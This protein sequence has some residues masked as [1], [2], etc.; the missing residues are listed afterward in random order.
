MKTPTQKRSI[1]RSIRSTWISFLTSVRSEKRPE[2]ANLAFGELCKVLSPIWKN[3]T[4]VERQPFV[5][6]YVNDRNRFLFDKLNLT[7][8]DKRAL[9]LLRLH[10]RKQRQTR[11]KSP[12]SAYMCF[13]LVERPKI[14]VDNATMTF[15]DV[16]RELGRIWRTLTVENRSVYMVQSQL[17]KDRYQTAMQQFRTTKRHRR[18]KISC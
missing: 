6:M 11:P 10:R 7:T 4:P 14:L 16:G 1:L 5:D 17:D 15:R 12:L 18:V 9:K 2:H 8:S 3:M 13:T